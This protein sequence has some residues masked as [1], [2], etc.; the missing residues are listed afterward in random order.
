MAAIDLNTVRSTIESRLSLELASAPVIPV[1]FNNMTFVLRE[2]NKIINYI[3]SC[4]ISDG[5]MANGQQS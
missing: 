1:V 3:G 5:R 2:P 4:Y